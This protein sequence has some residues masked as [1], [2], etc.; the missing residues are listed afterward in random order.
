VLTY[1]NLR[2]VGSEVTLEL[3]IWNLFGHQRS[4]LAAKDTSERYQKW[5]AIHLGPKQKLDTAP[6]TGVNLAEQ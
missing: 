2:D 1:P 6:A 5:P 4:V 3:P